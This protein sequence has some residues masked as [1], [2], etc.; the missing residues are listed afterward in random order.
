MLALLAQAASGQ[1]SAPAQQAEP[2]TEG[3][4]VVVTARRLADTERALKDCLARKCSPKE[5]IAATLAHAEALFLEGDYAQARHTLA[6][7]RGRNARHAKTLPVEVANLTRGYARLTSLDGRVDL[8]RTIGLDTIDALKA[9]LPAND[10]RVLMERIGGGDRYAALRRIDA[11]IDVYDAVAHD[12][13]AAGL[14]M[15]EGHA[16][17]RAAVLFGAAAG[18]DPMFKSD[19]RRRIARIEKTTEPAL[20]PFRNAATLLKAQLAAYDGDM[21]AIDRAIASVRATSAARPVLV[22][23]PPIDEEEVLPDRPLL[24]RSGGDTQAQ[25]ID[26]SFWIAPNGTVRDVELL[27]QSANLSGDWIER[28]RKALAKR[29]Y[30]PLAVDPKSPGVLRIERHSRVND[31]LVTTGSRMAGR[32]SKGRIE[33][34]DL[35]GPPPAS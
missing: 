19:A 12:A 9:G 20:A 31:V 4:T 23:A 25:W 2:A 35:T 32:S 28:S 15:V 7:S 22:Y 17:L 34:L 33:I 13:R 21:S 1:T 14:P 29:R 5:D 16:M 30:A 27:R 10:P 11:A 26:V 24:E 3:Q 6:A 18:G 8:S